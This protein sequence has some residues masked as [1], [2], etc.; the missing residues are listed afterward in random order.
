MW[1]HISYLIWH[2]LY[3]CPDDVCPGLAGSEYETS[4]EHDN[5]GCNFAY[6]V[7]GHSTN[8]HPIGICDLKHCYL[9]SKRET[10][11]AMQPCRILSQGAPLAVQDTIAQLLQKMHAT[12]NTIEPTGDED[13]ME[14]TRLPSINQNSYVSCQ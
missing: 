1:C 8:W 4:V 3:V 13:L 6:M 9:R 2:Q 12:I 10:Y 11:N 5:V 7:H 14:L